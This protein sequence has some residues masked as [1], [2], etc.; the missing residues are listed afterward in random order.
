V[1]DEAAAVAK[2]ITTKNAA[3][4]KGIVNGVAKEAVAASDDS[5][6]EII[7]NIEDGAIAIGNEIVK[8]A[9]AVVEAVEKHPELLVE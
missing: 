2:Q 3:D 6:A 1:I 7:E 5:I 9:E 8:G 4:I